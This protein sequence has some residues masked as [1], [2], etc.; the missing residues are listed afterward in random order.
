MAVKIEKTSLQESITQN[1]NSWEEALRVEITWAAWTLLNFIKADQ[2]GTRQLQSRKFSNTQFFTWSC[3]YKDTLQPGESNTYSSSI[4]NLTSLAAD[5]IYK[6]D[7]RT[8][9]SLSLDRLSN[10][11]VSLQEHNHQSWVNF[12]SLLEDSVTLLFSL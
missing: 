11:G 12:Q 3:S 10:R 8:G 4:I 6:F 7:F 9:E 5:R 1:I 2:V